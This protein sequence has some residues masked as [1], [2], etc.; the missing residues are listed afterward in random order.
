[1]V[2]ANVLTKCNKHKIILKNENNLTPNEWK[3]VSNLQQKIV[4]IYKMKQIQVK[5]RGNPA[6]IVVIKI[7]MRIAIYF[8]K[9]IEYKKFYF[10]EK[11]HRCGG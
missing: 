10:T 6:K 4:F 5:N 2:V 9:R 8:C 7:G 11:R 3:F 1:M